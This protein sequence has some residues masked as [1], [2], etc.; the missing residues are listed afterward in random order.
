GEAVGTRRRDGQAGPDIGVA[1]AFGL[2]APDLRAG[3]R[4]DGVGC[5]VGIGGTE[6][7][8]RLPQGVHRVGEGIPGPGRDLV[9]GEAPLGGAGGR[10]DRQDLASAG[11]AWKSEVN[12]CRAAGWGSR[13]GAG[14]QHPR[15]RR[16]GTVNGAR[17]RVQ[18]VDRWA[19][20]GG[21]PDGAV[22]DQ[23]RGLNRAD[24]LD[25]QDDGPS[26]YVNWVEGPGIG[27]DVAERLAAGRVVGDDRGVEY[28]SVEVR[29]PADTQPRRVRRGYGAVGGVSAQ[30]WIEV[31]LG[32]VV[33][34]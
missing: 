13:H 17:R 33:G 22:T 20:P 18:L 11:V 34:G 30:L 2:V 21:H 27:A 6:Q 25:R 12:G 16:V 29:G 14:E 15:V 3:D 19:G 5:V 28:R 4:I 9:A 23:R 24:E 26:G 32:P 1:S 10:G 8:Q 7:D 31:Q